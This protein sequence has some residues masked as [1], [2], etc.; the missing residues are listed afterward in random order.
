M[1]EEG[2]KNDEKKKFSSMPETNRINANDAKEK[3]CYVV[4]DYEAELKN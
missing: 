3:V 1:V 2:S 4:S